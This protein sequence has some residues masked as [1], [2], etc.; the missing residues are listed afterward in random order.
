MGCQLASLQNS[1]WVRQVHKKGHKME[2]TSCLVVSRLNMLLRAG[3][4]ENAYVCDAALRG[5]ASLANRLLGANILASRRC[6][7]HAP[8]PT[9]AIVSENH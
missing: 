2:S 5:K 8:N 9:M 3:A 7:R 1:F 4:Y 6:A